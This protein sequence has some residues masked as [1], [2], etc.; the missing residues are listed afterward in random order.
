M[1]RESFNLVE[2][3][4]GVELKLSCCSAQ[5]WLRTRLATLGLRP[6]VRVKVMQTTSGGAIVGVGDSRIAL[7][8]SVLEALQASRP[9]VVK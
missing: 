7:D 9:V 1:S 4:L 8:R 3:P 6:G 5:P 2:A